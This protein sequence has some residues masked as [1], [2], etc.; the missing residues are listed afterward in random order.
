MTG[1]ELDD[2]VE[3]GQRRRVIAHLVERLAHEELGALLVRRRVIGFATEHL[4]EFN[5]RRVVVL[6]VVEL[7]GPLQGLGGRFVVSWRLA[8]LLGCVDLVRLEGHPI[9]VGLSTDIQWGGNREG[10]GD[11]SSGPEVMTTH[12]ISAMGWGMP[13]LQRANLRCAAQPMSRRHRPAVPRR[14]ALRSRPTQRTHMAQAPDRSGVCR[15]AA[16]K[17]PGQERRVACL[18]TRGARL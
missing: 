2:A 6:A 14:R 3:I 1:L 5:G 4:G 15:P 16:A 17:I 13:Q 18:T 8:P 10:A 9:V 11:E 7:D 12:G